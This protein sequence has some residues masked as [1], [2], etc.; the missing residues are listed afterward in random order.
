MFTII[1]YFRQ[2]KTKLKVLSEQFNKSNADFSVF[3][4]IG[5][6]MTKI[7]ATKGWLMVMQIKS[8]VERAERRATRHTPYNSIAYAA[9]KGYTVNITSKAIQFL[10]PDSDKVVG[11]TCVDDCVPAIVKKGEKKEL[12]IA[13]SLTAIAISSLIPGSEGVPCDVSKAQAASSLIGL[14]TITALNDFYPGTFPTSSV[15]IDSAEDLYKKLESEDPQNLEMTE[16]ILLEEPKNNLVAMGHKNVIVEDKETEHNKV[17]QKIVPIKNDLTQKEVEVYRNTSRLWRKEDGTGLSGASNGY[18][19]G[20]LMS[21]AESDALTQLDVLMK[22]RAVFKEKTLIVVGMKQLA[23]CYSITNVAG[24]VVYVGSVREQYSNGHSQEAL[25]ESLS[26]KVVVNFKMLDPVG[27]S[28]TLEQD[29]R[30]KRFEELL[31]KEIYNKAGYFLFRLSTYIVPS[32]NLIIPTR[33]YHNM[34]VFYSNVKFEKNVEHNLL[35]MRMYAANY[36]RNN[37]F[38]CRTHFTNVINHIEK[39]EKVIAPF[40][41]KAPYSMVSKKIMSIPVNYLETANE[42]DPDLGNQ[43]APVMKKRTFKRVEGHSNEKTVS[44]GIVHER[45]IINAEEKRKDKDKGKEKENKKR[46]EESADEG[47]EEAADLE[48]LAQ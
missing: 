14:E 39:G 2:D 44:S 42:A 35:L 45:K 15:L 9:D 24:P 43:D 13:Q 21:K 7:F 19:F 23:K 33:N 48:L 34:H 37:W 8:E 32:K 40:K 18:G 25:P 41:F 10:D 3:G 27:L 16:T 6:E 5:E 12:K 29:E 36:V 30:E 46:I 1:D 17:V 4:T 38:V 28:L 26:D 20:V 11:G 31:E 22:I 47:S